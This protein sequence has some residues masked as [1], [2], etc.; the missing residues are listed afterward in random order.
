VVAE[1]VEAASLAST[2]RAGTAEELLRGYLSMEHRSAVARGCPVAALCSEVLHQGSA[3]KRA[4]DEAIA[5]LLSRVAAAGGDRKQVLQRAAS[6]VGALVLARAT[7]D[8]K[9]AAEMLQAVTEQIL[10]AA[11]FR[12]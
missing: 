6:M 2:N 8:E 9:L 11:P 10:E 3:T 7:A 5:R 1:A 4:F 12:R